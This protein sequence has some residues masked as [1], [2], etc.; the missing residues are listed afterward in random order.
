M[1]RALVLVVA[2]T[3]SS[4]SLVRVNTPPASAPAVVAPSQVSRHAATLSD[5][6]EQALV[7]IR[8]A[9]KAGTLSNDAAIR[10]VTAIRELSRELQ[11]LDGD[12]MDWAETADRVARA[13][14]RADAI[15]RVQRIGQIVAGFD[16]PPWWGPLIDAYLALI[17]TAGGA[18]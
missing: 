2:L 9:V 17:L 3:A 8:T 6:G 1:T 12:V 14:Q 13:Q 18:R 11:A 7:E 4:C 16:R 10:Q 5:A 15:T